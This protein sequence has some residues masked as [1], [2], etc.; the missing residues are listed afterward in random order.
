MLSTFIHLLPTIEHI[1]WAFGAFV[2]IRKRHEIIATLKRLPWW[3]RIGAGVLII[4]SAMIPG[5]LDD[6]IVLALIAK[7]AR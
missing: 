1:S 3:A 4:G 5:P 6:I 7:V 2:L